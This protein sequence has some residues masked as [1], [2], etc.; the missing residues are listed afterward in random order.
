[1]NRKTW[2]VVPVLLA[3]LGGGLWA[4]RVARGPEPAGLRGA[5]VPVSVAAASLQDVP[6]WLD[7]IGTVQAYYAVTVRPQ[8]DGQLQ[9]VV[10]KEG[11][12]VQAGDLLAQIDPRSFQAAL[13]Q[14]LAKKAEDQAQLANAQVDLARYAGLVA[15]HYVTQQQYDT[16]R[17][18]VNQLQATVLGDAA[19]VENTRVQLGYTTIRAPI[20]GRVGIRLIDPGNIVH[21]ADATGIVVI[22]QMHPIS[23]LFTL[24]QDDLPRVVRAMA[25]GPLDVVAASRDGKDVLDHGTLGLVDNQ[26]DPA[27]G[28]VKLKATMPNSAGVLWPGQFVDARLLIGTRHQ[29]VTVP[30][31]AV[32]HGQQGAYAYVVKPDHTVEPRPVTAAAAVGDLE[33]IEAGIA[34]GET[35]VTTGQYRLQPGARVEV[36]AAAAPAAPAAKAD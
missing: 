3:A 24:P 15:K 27:T 11:Q 34:D 16:T 14:A 29:V 25:A 26:I 35:V 6:Q 23:V 18:L 31:T 32:L 36:E 22:T 19:A 10:F 21:A 5:T 2:I 17:A 20:S 4:W 13:D 30:A 12:D 9:S 8:V 33:V 7:S 1:M 28:T